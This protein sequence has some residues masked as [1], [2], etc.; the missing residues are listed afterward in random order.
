MMF[1]VSSRSR[2]KG[3][4]SFLRCARRLRERTCVVAS[5]AYAVVPMRPLAPFHVIALPSLVVV[6][7]ACGAGKSPGEPEVVLTNGSGVVDTGTFAVVDT[8]GLTPDG[9]APPTS[10]NV[11][12]RGAD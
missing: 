9:T 1:A 4:S 3:G 2:A 10:T 12:L 6:L 5:T 11:T 7:A 8:G